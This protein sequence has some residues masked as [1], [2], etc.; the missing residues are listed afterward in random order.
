M[1]DAEIVPVDAA[2]PTT[3]FTSQVAVVF[4][5]PETVAV[6]CEVAPT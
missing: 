2:P 5:L 3:A 6:N 4:V 1:P